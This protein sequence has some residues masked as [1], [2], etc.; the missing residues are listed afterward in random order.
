MTLCSQVGAGFAEQLTDVRDL[1]NQNTTQTRLLA[2]IKTPM[3]SA[4][5]ATAAAVDA[6]LST[7]SLTQSLSL[8]VALLM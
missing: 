7:L 4:A 3:S 8:S 1:M 6:S 2:A 5:T